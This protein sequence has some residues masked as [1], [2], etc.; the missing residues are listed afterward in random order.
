MFCLTF[1]RTWFRGL[2]SLS[3]REKYIQSGHR[4][5]S[6]R[7]YTLSHWETRGNRTCC[8][9]WKRDL[10]GRWHTTQTDLPENTRRSPATGGS[11]EF[12]LC[13]WDDL[14]SQKPQIVVR[15]TGAGISIFENRWTIPWRYITFP[16]QI[17]DGYQCK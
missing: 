10:S 16:I 4:F 8:P 15:T 3:P 6:W 9:P 13:R 2:L 17:A 14:L 12:P 1:R 5:G 11:G 7:R